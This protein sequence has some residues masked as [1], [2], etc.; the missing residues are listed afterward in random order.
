[1]DSVDIE[2]LRE[3]L[4]WLRSGQRVTLVTVVK[5]WGSAPRAPGAMLAVRADGR[6]T[7]SVS[8]GCVEGDVVERIRA[9]FPTRPHAV[10]YG[11]SGDEARR[12]GLPCGGTLQL[13][14][15]PVRDAESLRQVLQAIEGRQMVTRTLDMASGQAAVSPAEASETLQFDGVRLISVHGPRWRLLLIG[16]GQ[17]SVYLARFA[18]ALD[19]GVIVCDPRAE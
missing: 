9:D 12:F 17:L 5:T 7:G 13:V 3:A 14:L 19:Y 8:G 6:F 18:M 15:E 4:A 1:M 16:A 2:V 11:V 10:S